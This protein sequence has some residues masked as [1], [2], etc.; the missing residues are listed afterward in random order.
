MGCREECAW[1]LVCAGGSAGKE[2]ADSHGG[3]GG[4]DDGCAQVLGDGSACLR[5]C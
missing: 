5:K 1:G 2:T 4:S 3:S